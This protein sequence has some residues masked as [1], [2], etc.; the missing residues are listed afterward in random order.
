LFYFSLILIK[1]FLLYRLVYPY[2]CPH[3]G[4]RNDSCACTND[5]HVGQGRTKFRKIRV[6][7]YNMKINRTNLFIFNIKFYINYFSIFTANDHTFSAIDYGSPVAYG[8]AGDCYSMSDC[9]QVGLF[10]IIYN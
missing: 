4:R 3:D 1:F 10:D 6:D 5:G 8:T 2:S 7:L 9:P